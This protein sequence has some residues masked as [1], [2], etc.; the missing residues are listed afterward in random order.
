MPYLRPTSSAEAV[1][2][3]AR[4][5]LDDYEFRSLDDGA[6]LVPGDELSAAS[7]D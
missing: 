6:A 3:T 1:R 7:V 5:P 2:A 4:F